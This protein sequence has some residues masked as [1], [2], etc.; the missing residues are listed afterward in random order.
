MVV[1]LDRT[2]HVTRKCQFAGILRGIATLMVKLVPT[3][4][5]PTTLRVSLHGTSNRESNVFQTSF[6]A[7]SSHAQ[8]RVYVC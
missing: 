6:T 4:T 1:R 3:V 2:P 5:V 7:L 8:C